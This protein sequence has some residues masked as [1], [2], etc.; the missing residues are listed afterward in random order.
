MTTKRF[1]A[2]LTIVL[3]AAAYVAG[4][5]PEHGRRLMLENE[6]SAL[7]ARLDDA[8]ARVR[9]ST[10]L[11]E[12]LHISETVASMNYGQAQTRSSRFFDDVRAEIDRTPVA[13]LRSA[14]ESALQRRDAITAAL[15]RGDQAAL[16]PLRALQIELRRA[17]GYPI[18]STDP[19]PPT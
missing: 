3:I 6:A 2:G 9:V 5:W 14:L 10:L 19:P 18:P 11:G 17:L 7:R 1:L 4:Y 8:E 13:E 16:E 15:S 12:L